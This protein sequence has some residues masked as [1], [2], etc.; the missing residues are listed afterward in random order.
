MA[1]VKLCSG[2]CYPTVTPQRRSKNDTLRLFGRNGRVTGQVGRHRKMAAWR[3]RCL[4]FGVTWTPATV[5][6]TQ[7]VQ[8][9]LSHSKAVPW[10]VAGCISFPAIRCSS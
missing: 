1:P 8:G 10:F 6:M 3:G 2:C 7:S 9:A 5:E 4:V